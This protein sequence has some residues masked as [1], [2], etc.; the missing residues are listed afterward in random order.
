MSKEEMIKVLN[1]IRVTIKQ[2][3][4]KLIQMLDSLMGCEVLIERLAGEINN[5]EENA[6]EH[7]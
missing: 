1:D 4:A 6:D 5:L 2:D 3:E 7:D